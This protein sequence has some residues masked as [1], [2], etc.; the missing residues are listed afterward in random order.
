MA[1]LFGCTRAEMG[2][3]LGISKQSASER[4]SGE[5]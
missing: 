2:H 1:L 4:F 5:E 3:A